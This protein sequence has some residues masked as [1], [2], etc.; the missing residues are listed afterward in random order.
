MASDHDKRY[1]QLFSNPVIVEELLLYFVDEDFVKN[2]DF[3]TLES[4]NKSFITDEFKEKESDII[5][6]IQYNGED[7]YVY[8]LIEFQS[9]VD[10][11]M[12]VRMLRYIMEFYQ[13]LIT[14]QRPKKLPAVFPVLLYNG[15]K[16]WTARTNVNELIEN[17]IPGSYIP[18]FRYYKVIENEISDKTLFEIKNVLSAVFY[19]ENI[20]NP[21]GIRKHFKNVLQLIEKEELPV[22][23]ALARWLNNYLKYENEDLIE[24]LNSIEEVKTMFATALIK[25]DQEIEKRGEQKGLEKGITEGITKGHREKQV[26]IAKELLANNVSIDIIVRATKLSKKQ[27][28]Q[29]KD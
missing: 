22:I 8:L 15:D 5:Y 24:E 20:D 6:K 13:A 4:V 12:A 25:H 27:I 21:A 19:I 28:E 9:T 2:L 18:D 14:L 23:K 17:T 11:F 29:L 16:K 26:E 3:S 7:I 1:K 10:K